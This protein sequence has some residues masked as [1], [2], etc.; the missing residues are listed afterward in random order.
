[1]LAY[2]PDHEPALCGFPGPAE[3]TSGPD[4]ARDD[5]VLI[6]DAQYIAEEYA[7]HV[8]WG[9]SA[10]PD[11]LVFAS[12]VGAGHLVPFHHDPA[13]TD[14][15][16]DALFSGIDEEVDGLRVTPTSAGMTVELTGG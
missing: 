4:L 9:H 15:D 7:A 3:W 14:D 6:H 8:G 13:H 12:A 1:M 16:L 5:D 10:L 2:L 11:T